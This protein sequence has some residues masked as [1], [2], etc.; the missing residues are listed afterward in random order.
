MKTQNYIF[1]TCGL[2]FSCWWFYIVIS[3]NIDKPVEW[4]LVA[5]VQTG[6]FLIII[7]FIQLLKNYQE[8][9]F[10]ISIL[11]ESFIAFIFFLLTVLFHEQEP[12]YFIGVLHLTVVTYIVCKYFN[13]KSVYKLK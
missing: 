7:F 3:A 11:F 9:K 6:I 10:K 2:I 13:H 12:A 1:H 5:I 4:D 8:N